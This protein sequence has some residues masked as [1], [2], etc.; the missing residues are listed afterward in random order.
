MPDYVERMQRR[1]APVCEECLPNVEAEIRRRDEMAR[2]RALGAFL[3]DSRGK[4]K[5]RMVETQARRDKFE[6]SLFVWKIRGGL[7]VVTLLASL[8]FHGQ[9]KLG[10]VLIYLKSLKLSWF[11]V[12]VAAGY[13][14]R[15]P[16]SIFPLI[17]VIVL[18]SI[19]W[20]AWDPTYAI[21]RRSQLQG[22]VMR[23]KRKHEYN[24]SHN[25]LYI[26]LVSYFFS[27]LYNL[28][29]LQTVAWCSRL[30]VSTVL[31]LPRYFS[32]WGYPYFQDPI[33]TRTRMFSFVFCLLEFL[34]SPF[35]SPRIPQLISLTRA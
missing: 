34:V 28:K 30:F 12:V 13:I 19:A 33:P 7:W 17:P 24:V 6:K 25:V 35:R 11:F 8:G 29:I 2:T 32:S 31:I 10:V 9:G 27:V 4:D 5:R 23:Q 3:K 1:Y 15:I 22:R 21:I 18:F 26:V 20:T 14:L 16:W